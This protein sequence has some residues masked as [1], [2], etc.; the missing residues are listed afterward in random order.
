MVNRLPNILAGCALVLVALIAAATLHAQPVFNNPPCTGVK[1]INNNA[2]CTAQFRF[3]TIPAGAWPV[4]FNVPPGGSVG[5]PI[6][7]T[8]ITVTGFTD[9]F[10]VFQTFNAP[11]P[12]FTGCGPTGWWRTGVYLW[13]ALA[14]SFR[15][16]ADPATCSITVW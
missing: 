6:P 2:T 8:G 10:G 3:T 12:T 15:I 13:P 9:A 11:P 7:A 14:C 1:V 4:S 5:L 16:C